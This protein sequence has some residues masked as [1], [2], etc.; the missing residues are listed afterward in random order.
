MSRRGKEPRGRRV[1]TE[2]IH[3]YATWKIKKKMFRVQMKIKTF[4]RCVE[5]IIVQINGLKSVFP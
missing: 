3:E 2:K 1:E 5:L 4:L